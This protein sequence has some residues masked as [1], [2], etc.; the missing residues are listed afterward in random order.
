MVNLNQFSSTPSGRTVVSIID[1]MFFFRG[2]IHTSGM[3]IAVVAIYSVVVAVQL[4][5]LPVAE[6]NYIASLT[7]PSDAKYT[8]LFHSTNLCE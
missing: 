8:I 3:Y 4:F 6:S 1:R 7:S 2:C 5:L